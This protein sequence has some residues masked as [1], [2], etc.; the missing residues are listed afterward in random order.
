MVVVLAA[1]GYPESYPKG[2]VITR[3]QNRENAWVIHAG[4]TLNEAQDVVT[5]GGRVLGVVGTGNTLKEASNA[6]YTLC[7]E[8]KFSSKFLRR[9]IGWRQ[10][11]REN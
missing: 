3:P 2:D 7:D 8:V 9:D 4:T 11:E 10:L 6:A 1:K 5:S